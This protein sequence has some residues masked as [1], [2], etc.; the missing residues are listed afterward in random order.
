MAS[1]T[2]LERGKGGNGR[3]IA[4]SLR[5]D[6]SDLA[7]D[8]VTLG[9]LQVQLLAEDV[10]AMMRSAR[11]WAIV[12]VAACLLALGSLPIIVL[13]LAYLLAWTGLDLALSMLI[14]AIAFLVLT[15]VVA[16]L[17]VRRLK[18]A[19][20]P[21]GRSWH[22]LQKNVAWIKRTLANGGRGDVDAG[23]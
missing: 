6:V 12:L 23:R 3:S 4:G 1:Q 13:G 5:E 10:R 7:H 9:E 22:E 11:R 2:S 15:A 21:L 20:E 19:A 14:V 8:V 18:T 16:A 17:S